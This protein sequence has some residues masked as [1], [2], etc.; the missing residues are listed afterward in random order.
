MAEYESAMWES[1]AG[2]Y[3]EAAR[4]L[5]AVTKRDPAWLDP[6]IELAT[7]Y[8]R[9]HRPEDGAKQRAIITQLNAQQQS[10]GPGKP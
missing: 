4:Q 1:T 8:Y 5:E 3:E 7:V 6:H 2:K 9:L 10:K